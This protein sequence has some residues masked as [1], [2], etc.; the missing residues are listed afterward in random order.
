MAP[1][2]TARSNADSRGQKQHHAMKTLVHKWALGWGGTGA[3]GEKGRE[4]G[5]DGE[6]CCLG[7]VG[8][9]VGGE[10]PQDSLQGWEQGGEQDR[11]RGLGWCS[12]GSCCLHFTVE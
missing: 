11:R 4:G 8:C 9:D 2:S 3:G 7:A 6:L 10:E 5:D 1:N 12:A